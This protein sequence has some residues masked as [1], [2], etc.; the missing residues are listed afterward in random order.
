MENVNFGII[1]ARYVAKGRYIRLVVDLY[2]R[3]FARR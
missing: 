3:K 1:R 2:I